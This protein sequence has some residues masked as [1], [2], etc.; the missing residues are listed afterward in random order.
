MNHTFFGWFFC[1]PPRLGSHGQTM[2]HLVRKG[3][4]AQSIVNGEPFII[5]GGEWAIQELPA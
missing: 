2:P 1:L 3:T 4:A 5:A